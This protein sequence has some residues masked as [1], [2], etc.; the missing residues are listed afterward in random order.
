MEPTFALV[1]LVL[2][3]A[4]G[5]LLYLLKKGST[6]LNPPPPPTP[7]PAIPEQQQRD[8]ER[9]RAEAEAEAARD[10]D[11]KIRQVQEQLK[12]EVDNNPTLDDVLIFL[13]D[14]GKE[15][16]DDEAPSTEPP[17]SRPTIH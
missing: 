12:A 5:A 2:G 11:R 1:S 14:T 9:R 16:R 3:A 4:F 6:P 13:Q 15:V 8:L 10:H 17:P 7:T